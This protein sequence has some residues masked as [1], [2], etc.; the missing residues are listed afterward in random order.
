[1]VT[2]GPLTRIVVESLSSL[3]MEQGKTAMVRQNITSVHA[4]MSIHS[5]VF[6][7]LSFR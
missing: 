2:R 1:M 3:L 5:V 4:L 6:S 7:P